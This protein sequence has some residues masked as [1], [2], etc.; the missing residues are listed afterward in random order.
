MLALATLDKP[1]LL[2]LDEPTNHLDID[3]RSELLTA[4]NDFDGAVVLVSHDRRLIEAT[5]DRLLLVADGKVT[6][7]EGD[8]DDYRRFLLSGDNAPTRRRRAGDQSRTKEIARRGAA[9]RR[10]ELKPLKDRIESAESQ[11]AAL[12]AELA[13]L[14]KAW[15]IP[16]CSPAIPPKAAPSPRSAPKRRANLAAVESQWLA[17]QEEY[18]I[19]AGRRIELL[20]PATGGCAVNHPSFGLVADEFCV[21]VANR[22]VGARMS[23]SRFFQP[24]GPFSL[25]QIAE[26]MGAELAHPERQDDVI[27][28]IAELADAGRRRLARVLRPATCRR[29]RQL[30]CQRGRHQQEAQRLSPQW[31][32]AAPGRRSPPGLRR[33]GRLFYPRADP[34]PSSIPAPSSP[35]APVIG[36]DTRN[37]LRRHGGRQC[38]DRIALPHRRQCRDRRRRRHRRWHKDRRQ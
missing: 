25:G 34:K 32:R 4:L 20:A 33:I 24:E 23:D 14:D 6:P 36:E 13:K 37:R 29:V 30:P 31:R 1:N 5:A 2:I 12:Q 9:E 19:G 17:A 26:I 35:P 11:I 10:R 15:P 7:F 18:E 28:D 38:A 16:C 27:H 21:S 22:H 3:A 8:L